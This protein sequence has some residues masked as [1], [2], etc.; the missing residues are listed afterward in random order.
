MAKNKIKDS[1]LLYGMI[2]CLD[3]DNLNLDNDGK[4]QSLGQAHNTD[5]ENG[6]VKMIPY[7]YAH[8]KEIE[9]KLPKGL[10]KYYI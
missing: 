9:N 1:D 7:A 8:R 10:W 4:W 6:G 2:E 3:F 5:I